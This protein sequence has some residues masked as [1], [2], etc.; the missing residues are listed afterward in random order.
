MFWRRVNPDRLTDTRCVCLQTFGEHFSGRRKIHSWRELVIVSQR[1]RQ[2]PHPLEG[3]TRGGQLQQLE[4]WVGLVSS[5]IGCMQDSRGAEGR[6]WTRK[7]E[8]QESLTVDLHHRSDRPAE[9]LCLLSKWSWGPWAF[10]IWR[11]ERRRSDFKISRA[12][13]EEDT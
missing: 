7:K 10:F 2:G 1:A 9:L 11:I 6:G 13:T 8:Q 12:E 3:L 4:C 5:G